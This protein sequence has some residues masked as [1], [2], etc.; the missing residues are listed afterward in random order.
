MLT[1]ATERDDVINVHLSE[2]HGQAADSAATTIAF[3]HDLALD[4]LY[5]SRTL[6][7]STTTG[8]NSAA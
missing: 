6:L 1:T 3:P 4:V 2:P 7:E 8:Y 5:P